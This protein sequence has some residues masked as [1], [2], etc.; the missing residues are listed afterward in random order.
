MSASIFFL[1]SLLRDESCG[2]RAAVGGYAPSEWWPAQ[3]ADPWLCAQGLI[4]FF[5]L[6]SLFSLEAYRILSLHPV[7]GNGI[8]MHVCR[9]HCRL[10]AGAGR[11]LRTPGHPQPSSGEI[12]PS[13]LLSSAS[14]LLPGTAA[15]RVAIPPEQASLL[16]RSYF[17]AL[18]SPTS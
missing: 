6:F 5:L 1:F 18:P 3:P 14:S 13:D 17:P 10:F 12:F 8:R 16:L 9:Q 15:L 7:F 4:L 11:D 2:T